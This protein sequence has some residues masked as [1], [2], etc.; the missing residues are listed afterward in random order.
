[1]AWC[2]D[3][4]IAVENARNKHN[5]NAKGRDTLVDDFSGA[6]LTHPLDTVHLDISEPLVDD[7]ETHPVVEDLGVYTLDETIPDPNNQSIDSNE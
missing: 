5:I 1:M 2:S 7:V 4:E 3:N 6:D